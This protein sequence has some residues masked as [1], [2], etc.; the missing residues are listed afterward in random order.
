MNIV[1]FLISLAMGGIGGFFL[2]G[3]LAGKPEDAVRFFAFG[4][5]LLIAAVMC[6]IAAAILDYLIPILKEIRGLRQDISKLA[7]P[8]NPDQD[9]IDRANADGSY[10]G[11][12][13]SAFLDR[14]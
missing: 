9:A 14:L 11:N 6:F 1:M 10:L 12:K 13:F 8:P 4:I 2:L 7:P 3:A 5:P